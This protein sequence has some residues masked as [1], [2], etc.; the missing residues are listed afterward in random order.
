[1]NALIE[2]IFQAGVVGCG[3]AGFPTHKKLDG[4]FRWLI[5]NGAEC[6]PL[7]RTDRYLMIHMADALVCAIDAVADAAQ[8]EHR[9]IGLKA[10]YR[11]EIA[12]L[13]AAIEK[14]G[15][16]IQLHRMESF[17]PAGDEQVLVYE[18]TGK[19]VPPAGIP[20]DV[21]AAVSNV[22]TM[23][24]ISDAM[25]G[26]PLCNKYI[27]VT[28]E[29]GTPCIVHAPIG[30]SIQACIEAAG[31][32]KLAEYA[33]VVGGPMMGKY[34]PPQQVP[35]AVVTKT[36][37]GLIV[38]AEDHPLALRRDPPMQAIL[39]RAKSVC[40]QCRTCTDLCPRHLLG[41][42]LEPHRIMR[43][44]AYAPD[45]GQLLAEVDIQRAMLCS[46]CGVCEVVACPMGLHP[47]QV[48]VF[49]KGKLRAS[50]F[51]YQRP[52]GP[53]AAKQARPERLIP[54]AR[55]A[56]RAGVGAY[57]SLRI[58]SLQ[59]LKPQ[60]VEILLQQHIG[61]PARAVVKAGEQV[62]PNQLVAACPE[63]ALGA[64]IHTGI[65]GTVISVGD[66][67]VIEQRQAGDAV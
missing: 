34:L 23:L 1:M 27:T 44:M 45:A 64:N 9:V 31:G 67:I 51:R 5:I 36:T 6:E 38:L 54:T 14:A 63:G 12:A 2:K 49:L 43:Q 35:D 37:S 32:A 48:N 61:A 57:Q 18:V 26:Q 52:A 66:R 40:I 22:A 19:V 11:R 53:F 7:L 10:S 20:L 4:Q 46:E 60:R 58:D 33:V 39:N 16:K 24:A 59:E 55:A 17:Y 41:H 28:G 8:A 47:R 15:S 30:T 42:P 62:Q 29:V 21:G 56:S 13:E 3:G 25:Q 65:G 50:G